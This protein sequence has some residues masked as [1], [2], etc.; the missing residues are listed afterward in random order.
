M[1]SRLILVALALGVGGLLPATNL[2]VVAS[3]GNEKVAMV[4]DCDPNADWGV[5]G[6]LDNHND[7][8][9]T[10]AEFMLFL[11]SPLSPTTVV[12]HPSWR[13]DPGYLTVEDGEKV[14]VKNLGGRNHTF[15]RVDQFGGGTVPPLRVGLLPAP[16]CPAAVL[17]GPGDKVEVSKTD[18]QP[19]DNRFMCCIHSWMRTVIKVVPDE[20]HGKRGG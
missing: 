7:G 17:V 4:D 14:R 12:G 6:C 19:G 16:E 15:T 3:S 11:A 18:L 8:N 5:G 9:V 20:K 13:N 10:R 2:S 1:R